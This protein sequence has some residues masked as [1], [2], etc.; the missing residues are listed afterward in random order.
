MELSFQDTSG[1]QGHKPS[2]LLHQLQH[3]YTLISTEWTHQL[4]IERLLEKTEEKVSSG[5][6]WQENIELSESKYL[7]K[8][9]MKEQSPS[10]I[11]YIP[12]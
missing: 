3:L 12:V 9:K 8:G 1:Q 5:Q 2:M 4:D 7:T 11:K 10:T 6:S